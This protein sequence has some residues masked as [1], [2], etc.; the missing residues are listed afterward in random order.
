MSETGDA[1]AV[2][3]FSEHEAS[4]VAAAVQGVMVGLRTPWLR[5][6]AQQ[7]QAASEADPLP[8]EAQRFVTMLELSYLVASADGFAKAERQSLSY[9]L[10]SVTGSAVKQ[11]D[12]ERHFS[13]LD[14]AVAALGRRERLAASAAAIEDDTGRQEAI[15]LTA[16]IAMA[17]GTLSRPE[18]DALLELSGHMDMPATEAEALVRKAATHVEEALR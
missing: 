11:A 5:E 10:Q 7:T 17:D 16:L 9:L 12:L 8:T 14:Q 18:M 6:G 1:T 13:D 15:L 2:I 4:E 3:D